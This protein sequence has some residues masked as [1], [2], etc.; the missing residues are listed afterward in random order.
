VFDDVFAKTDDAVRLVFF[1]TCSFGQFHDT[2][3]F[4][5]LPRKQRAYVQEQHSWNYL[6][7]ALT[8]TN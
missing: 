3:A 8:F 5:S 2:A 4:V 1:D 7:L 6:L